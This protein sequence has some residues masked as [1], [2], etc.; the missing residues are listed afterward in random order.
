LQ[1]RSGFPLLVDERVAAAVNRRIATPEARE[2]TR[3]A[4]QRMR[5]YR[6]MIEDVLGQ[7]GL[8]RELL[9]MAL[10]E[11]GFDNEA[12]PNR[13]P[14]VQ[15]AG[16][17]QIIPGVARK[18]G[19][20]V[21]PNLDERLEP[22]RATEAA[23]SM[24]ADLHRQFGDWPLAIAA[25]NG[26]SGVVRKLATG[27]SVEE[28]RARVLASDTEFGRYLPGVMASIVLIENPALAD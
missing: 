1:A 24:L 21:T 8:P 20:Q 23:A 5:N 17:W 16:I 7:R 13:P 26:G 25:Y 18:L 19:L 22:R 4:L 6:V 12:R 9:G 28:A 11:S 10:A 3:R 27:V 15:S 2:L 14:Q